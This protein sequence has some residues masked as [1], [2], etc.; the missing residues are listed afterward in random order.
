MASPAPGPNSKSD[1]E[2]GRVRSITSGGIIWM[3]ILVSTAAEMA[4]LAH[5]YHFHSL[6][7]D[8]CLSTMQLDEGGRSRRI[9]LHH[10]ANPG[11]GRSRNKFQSGLDVFGEGL[12][13]DHSSVQP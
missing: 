7:L 6:D 9:F 13:R 1:S 2:D 10:G 3:D 4:M 5:D 8:S 11:S 12:S